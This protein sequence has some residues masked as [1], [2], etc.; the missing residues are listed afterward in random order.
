MGADVTPGYLAGFLVP[1]AWST[2]Y[3]TDHA[4]GTD[5]TEAS[6]MTGT[7]TSSGSPRMRLEAVGTPETG[8]AQVYAQVTRGGALGPDGAGVV[9]RDS[10]GETWKGCEGYGILTGYQ[11]I[12][13]LTRRGVGAVVREDGTVVMVTTS[14]DGGTPNTVTLRAWTRSTAGAWSGADV[15]GYL[16]SGALT[17]PA[18]ADIIT[19]PDGSLHA[20]A[21]WSADRGGTWSVA[22]FRSTD[23]GAT[24]TR[25]SSDVGISADNETRWLRFGVLGSGQVVAWVTLDTGTSTDCTQYVSTDGGHT[26]S[27]VA[28]QAR[29]AVWGVTRAGGQLVVL[30]ESYTA[31]DR[32]RIARCGD[33]TASIFAG[34]LYDL[35]AAPGTAYVSGGGIV[36]TPAGE[37]WA[38]VCA[39]G[40]MFAYR[41]LDSGGTWAASE[42]YQ[43]GASDSPAQ[44]VAV[45]VRGEVLIL[46]AAWD[47]SVLT[48]G[49]MEWRFGGRS[50]VTLDALT[51]FGGYDLAWSPLCTLATGGWAATDSGTPA[52]T[53]S[54]STGERIV[55]GGGDQ[56]ISS[57]T[58]GVS[59]RSVVGRWVVRP[60][61]GTT[62]LALRNDYSTVQMAI[63]IDLTTTSIEAYDATVG[64]SSSTAGTFSGYVEVVA[65][66]AN[67]TAR[68]AVWYRAH[69]AGGERVWSQLTVSGLADTGSTGTSHAVAI[70]TSSECY[71]RECGIGPASGSQIAD[72]VTRP[73]DL[74]P[75]RL[76]AYAPMYLTG[77]VSVVAR[78]GIAAVD[79]STY[80]IP[81]TSIYRRD[82]MLPTVQPSP[83]RP[84]RSGGVTTQDLRFTLDPSTAGA[85][86]VGSD[87]WGLY[88]DRLVGVS[89]V[90]IYSGTGAGTLIATADLRIALTYAQ[91]GGAVIPSASGSVTEG[92]W[93][94]RDELAGGYF[95]C[96]NGEVRRIASNTSGTLTKG[97][98]IAENR[99][100]LY[101]DDID[102]T[103]DS[104]GA[105]YI[106]PPRALIYWYLRGSR[107]L[108]QVRLRIASTV[109]A[110]PEGYR[111]IGVLA[112]G[113]VHVLGR[114]WDRAE[115][116]EHD[117]GGEIATLPDGSRT[118]AYRVPV[119]RRVEVAIVESWLATYD[120]LGATPQP[121][122]VRA[123]LHASSTPTSDAWGGALDLAGL[124][125]EVRRNPIVYLPNI[126]IDSGS[127]DAVVVHTRRSG[128]GAVYGRITSSV[129]HEQVAAGSTG[130]D[131]I[132][133]VTTVAFDEEV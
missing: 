73:G 58:L 107:S 36:T 89:Q 63:L 92:R 39:G 109:A 64:P 23:A 72:G 2:S 116:T 69:D 9:Y 53:L 81:V 105:G 119:R 99:A 85:V 48:G 131:D 52:R 33:G 86:N 108:T 17:E 38:Y 111:E 95:E 31:S 25:Q 84:W 130:T 82:S 110:P 27:S 102:G 133:R 68:A 57:E 87:V 62:Q 16:V 103:E 28:T 75:V 20:Y 121:D 15:E 12:S 80:T 106:H 124:A 37:V 91:S 77:G 101:L 40:S 117:P 41:S 50:D 100:T 11:S 112:M 122:Y 32:Y 18:G 46:G 129:R 125:H 5:Y 90:A 42:G 13:T 3:A 45:H 22:C 35:R 43:T 8:V 113:P 126:P 83:S 98:T 59:T 19:A 34:S 70:G 14:E 78:G 67:D 76:S 127:G 60:I 55:T 71:V 114:A 24:W 61:T 74:V 93:V 123:S 44:V 56:A 94:A 65:V 79:G 120:V 49:L 29:A 97:S 96:A 30:L 54:Q 128:L 21:R 6:P 88:L 4:L 132:H 66:I 115:A 7:P 47:S 51:G 104:S 118:V 1:W 26:F 10:T